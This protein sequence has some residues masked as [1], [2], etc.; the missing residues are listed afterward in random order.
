MSGIIRRD[1]DEDFLDTRPQQ[2]PERIK[3]HRFIIH[4][5]E[6]LTRYFRQRQQSCCLTTCEDD[7]FHTNEFQ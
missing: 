5:Q 7:A 4:G 1:D 3:D 2:R 6:L